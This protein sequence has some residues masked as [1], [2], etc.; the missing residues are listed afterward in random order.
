MCSSDL[1]VWYIDNEHAVI[2]YAEPYG[3]IGSGEAV[4]LGALSLYNDAMCGT[5]VL[6]S[7][8]RAAVNLS[9]IAASK[10]TASC[11]PPHDVICQY[12]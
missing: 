12:I 7:S 9:L 1:G 2:H 8:A 3:A 10:H 6:Q 5:G 11:V 4:A